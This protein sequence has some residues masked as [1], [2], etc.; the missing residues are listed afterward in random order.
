MI[1]F[2]S[3]KI[4]ELPGIVSYYGK[5]VLLVTG[6]RSFM[7]SRR[8]GRLF[9]LFGSNGITFQH[10]TV[11]SE[12][13]P[14]TV[15]DTVLKFAGREI[16]AVVSIGGGSVIDAGKA[17][18][19]MLGKTGSVTEYLEV[20]GN[21]EHPGTKVP[22]I[23]VP[24]TSGTGSEA[25]KNAVISKVGRDGFKRSLRHDNFV[26]DAAIVDHELTL[27]CPPEITAAAGM[28]CF[29]QLTEAYL[30]TKANEYTDAL[31]LEG[32]MAI[33][34]SLV[35]SYTH[36]DDITARSDMSF[37][38]L[39]SGICLA[40]AGLG[41]VHGLAGTIGAL[42][43]IPHGVVCGTLMADANDLNVRELR[44][45]KNGEAALRKYAT[46]GRLFSDTAVKSDNYYIDFFLDY[47]RAVTFFLDLPKL[48]RF[49]LNEEDLPVICSQSDVKNNPAELSAGILSEILARRL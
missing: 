44:K 5:S 6:A 36:G 13:S 28:D 24:T 43:D 47:L 32:I 42:F 8:A 3:G 25:T 26:P 29:T 46:L 22:F 17:I 31:A 14:Q 45:G 9:D 41:A 15:D 30:S 18:S 40:N 12:P 38:A 1:Y 7:D 11:R 37:A 33:K 34:R 16:N 35:R 48:S 23:A 49:G 27:E 21:K 4:S 2:G 10:V 20:V 19:A 39:T